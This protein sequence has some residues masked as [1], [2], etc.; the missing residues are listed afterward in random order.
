[1]GEWSLTT[2]LFKTNGE[3]N[4]KHGFYVLAFAMLFASCVREELEVE[5]PD[6]S[7]TPQVEKGLYVPGEMNVKF[8]EELTAMIEEDL[9]LGKLQTKSSELNM[10]FDELGVTSVKRLCDHGGEYEPRMRAEGLHRWYRVTFSEKESHTKAVENFAHMSGVDIAEPVRQIVRKDFTGYNDAYLS[11]LWAFDNGEYDIN[12]KPVWQNYTTGN[13]NV[14]VAVMDGGVD[15]SHEDLKDNCSDKYINTTGGARPDP[16]FHGTHVAGTIAAVGNNG[17]GV[18]GIAGGDY[19]AG[20]KGVKIMSC[21]ILS[22]QPGRSGNFYNAM[23]YAANNG[24]VISQNSWGYDYDLDGDGALTGSEMVMALNATIQESD[25][26]AVDYFIKYAGVDSNGNQRANSP[27]K[28]GIVVFAA[29]NDGIANGAPAN[30]DAVIAVG[31]MSRNG[32]RA[33]FSCYGD[34]VDVCAPGVEILSTTPDGYEYSQGTSMACPHVSGVAALVLSYCGGQGF[35]NEMLWEKI[36]NSTNTSAVPKS[37][38]I[39]GLLDAHKAIEYGRDVE[40]GEIRNLTVEAVS[41]N[42]D[43]SVEVTADAEGAAVYGYRVLYGTDRAKVESANAASTNVKNFSFVPELPVGQT[44]E[45]RVSDLEFEKTYYLKVYSYTYGMNYSEPTEIYEVV[46]GI[47][48]APEVSVIE[49]DGGS[50]FTAAA[51]VDVQLDVTDRDGHEVTVEHT[52]GS[53]ADKLV[54]K[55]SGWYLTITANAA[56]AGTYTTKI[57]VTDAYGLS[58][59]TTYTYTIL[60]NAAPEVI[61]E[62]EDILLSAKGKE[63]KIDM[64]EY[65]M[66]VDQDA[67]TLVYE[68]EISNPAVLHIVPRENILYGTALGYGNTDVTIVAK[69]ARGEKCKLTFKVVVKNPSEPVSLYPNP[70]VDFLNVST[71]DIKDTRVRIVSQTGQAVYDKVSRIG[72]FEP[73]KIDMRGC[74]PGVYSV[75]VTIDGKETRQNIIKL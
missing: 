3:L 69:D 46:T 7:E 12:V 62:I 41:N 34:W 16:E 23:V 32:G 19:A 1:M 56:E 60:P 33:S 48:N 61:A 55:S 66:D 65:V 68:V 21:Q 35:T 38:K 5:Q 49:P 40:P 14:I 2:H 57:K 22:E 50:E 24:A 37:Y 67:S 15:I 59:Q 9:A 29:G 51:V 10:I 54:Q 39:G 6:K 43:F 17:K 44:A 72:A 13:P 4:M 45:F 74:A 63:F 64:S 36:V 27:M 52:P 71:M 25:K 58:D 70:V 20:Q 53:D 31:A 47:N 8:S 73:A 42:I 26:Q 18:V 75:S 30:Y 11:D 28:G